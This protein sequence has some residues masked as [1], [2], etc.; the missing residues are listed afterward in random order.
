MISLRP[1]FLAMAIASA[2]LGAGGCSTE[3]PGEW[4][5]LKLEIRDR[6]PTVS[7]MTSEEL[8]TALDDSPPPILLDARAEEEFEVSH[9]RGAISAPTLPAAMTAVGDAPTDQQII[10]YCSVGYRS[11]Q[12]AGQLSEAGYTNVHNHEGSIFEWANLGWTVYRG[13]EEVEEVHPFDE[14]WGRLLRRDRWSV[15]PPSDGKR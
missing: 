10:V 9:L 8:R 2:A 6:F 7:Q 5:A 12:M 14:E 11:S 15:M 4:A 13:D 3:E 1:V